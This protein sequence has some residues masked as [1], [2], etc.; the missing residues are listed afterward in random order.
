MRRVIYL[1]GLYFFFTLFLVSSKLHSQQRGTTEGFSVGIGSRYLAMGGIASTNDLNSMALFW[2]PA[3]ID[4]IERM[5]V[6]LFATKLLAD[7]WY[8]SLGAVYPTEECGSFGVNYLRIECEV[9]DPFSNVELVYREQE[10]LI[11]YGKRMNRYLSIGGSVKIKHKKVAEYSADAVGADFGLLYS[12]NFANLFL[13]NTFASIQFR[14]IV[15]P[16]FKYEGSK[17]PEIIQHQ[18]KASIGRN[19]HISNQDL[20][21]LFGMN[22]NNFEY[23]YFHSALEYIFQ[24]RFSAQIGV[25][26]SAL[27]VGCGIRLYDLGLDLWHGKFSEEGPSSFTGISLNYSFGKSKDKKIAESEHKFKLEVDEEYRKRIAQKRRDQFERILNE[28]IKLYNQKKYIES[29]AAFQKALELYP[30]SLSAQYWLKKTREQ[31]EK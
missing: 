3:F 13:K 17:Y 12:P 27:N 9:F 15:E 6:S 30:Y 1:S 26:N 28:G 8:S 18:F 11:G 16:K 20:H 5:N 7:T 29:G 14:N 25:V 21:V 2:N 24:N 22:S 10:V 23:T 4:N 19:F 31:L